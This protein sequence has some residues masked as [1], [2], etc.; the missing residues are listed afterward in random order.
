MSFHCFAMV[1]RTAATHYCVTPSQL[2]LSLFLFV[3]S[4]SGVLLSGERRTELKFSSITF[5]QQKQRYTNLYCQRRGRVL[6]KSELLSLGCL[7]TFW[8]KVF[9]GKPD[10]YRDV[11]R[12]L[13]CRRSSLFFWDVTQRTLSV[14]DVSGQS[15]D[16]IFQDLEDETD[17]LSQNVGDYQSTLRNI[18]EERRPHLRRGGGLISRLFSLLFVASRP[19][20]G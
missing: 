10:N 18:P 15:I 9:S 17:S 13:N 1:K 2:S 14:T 7:S 12:A 5:C 4:G 3:A 16:P 6:T 19:K 11:F 8:W 20:R